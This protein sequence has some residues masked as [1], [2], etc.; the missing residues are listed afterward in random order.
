ME[1]GKK[2]V[3]FGVLLLVVIIAIVLIITSNK[4]DSKVINEEKERKGEPTKEL[5]P[6]MEKRA[7]DALSKGISFDDPENDWYK[8]PEGSMQWDKPDNPEPYPLPFT[9]LKQVKI[10]AD[11]EYL[12]VKFIFYGEFPDKMPSYNGDDLFSTG[13]KID[14]MTY[15]TNE[16]TLDYAEIG[17]GVFYVEFTGD[18]KTEEYVPLDKP[19]LGHIAMIS[20]QGLDEHMETIYKTMNGIGFIGGGPGYDYLLSAF[21]LSEFGI[22]YGQEMNFSVAVESGS[23]LWHHES[24]DLLLNKNTSKFGANIKYV[25]GED[26]YEFVPSQDELEVKK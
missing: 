10:G 14:Q 20:P 19:S 17:S 22:S 4:P 9:D 11:E 16:G 2:K 3:L 24:V 5:T 8:F 12:Y 15:M 7:E 25:L 26:K 6:A 23:N 18:E 21:P 13:A 1:P